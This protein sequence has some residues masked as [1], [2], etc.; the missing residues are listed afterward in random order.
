M[1]YTITL[2]PALDYVMFVGK[3]RYD[4][5]NRSR[6][7]ALFAGG[8]GINVSTVL[9]E[10]DVPSVALGFIAG[11]TGDEIERRL[12]S[13]GIAADFTRVKKGLTRINV[14]IKAETELDVN[15]NGPEVD[16]NEIAALM[17]KLD[18]AREGDVVI[19]AGAPPK[20]LPADIYQQMLKRLDGRGVRF[21]VDAEG[22][23]LKNAL[24]YKPLLIKPNH[25]ELA[26][27]FGVPDRLTEEEIVHYAR[28]LQK[29][30]ARNVLVSRGG[31]GALL[32]DENGDVHKLGSLPGKVVNTVGAGDS[33]VAGF[34]A[35][36]LKTGDY[37]YALRLGSACGNATA[38]SEGLATREKIDRV[39]DNIKQQEG[40][41][42]ENH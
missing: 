40:G 24:P 4:D 3:L 16:E 21:V 8:K 11:F 20:N 19:L 32:V 36:F 15:A 39:L 18:A 2:N 12:L 25:H 41:T 9:R 28:L 13:S 17:E 37:A 31:D 22:D 35:G 10:L 30:G 14:K 29:E 6:S 38:L 1:V 7:E 27:L 42:H 33:M 5:I 26:G 23:L 34:V